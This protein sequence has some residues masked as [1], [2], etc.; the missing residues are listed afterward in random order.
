MFPVQATVA[1]AVR[2]NRRQTDGQRQ[3]LPQSGKAQEN[4]SHTFS[5]L[6]HMTE[7]SNS[8][9]EI[10]SALTARNANEQN[11]CKLRFKCILDC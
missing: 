6:D 9:K 10:S 5:D 1:P 2:P 3:C 8:L 4:P 11:N 7:I